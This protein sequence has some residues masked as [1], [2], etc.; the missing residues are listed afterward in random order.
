MEHDL[1]ELSKE[2]LVARLE[3][4]N[5]H[6]VT[7]LLSRSEELE[8]RLFDADTA[9]EADQLKIKKLESENKALLS[10][11]ME[12]EQQLGELQAAGAKGGASH[13]QTK[14]KLLDLEQKMHER[15][16]AEAATSKAID[17]L[18]QQ[19]AKV[20]AI[21]DTAE[22]EKTN[23][24]RNNDLRLSTEHAF[25]ELSRQYEELMAS[26]EAQRNNTERAQR[27]ASE[28]RDKLAAMEARALQA[29]AAAKSAVK[30]GDALRREAEQQRRQAEREVAARKAADE[31]AAKQRD[32][33]DS[34]R[35]QLEAASLRE[36][37]L[38]ADLE[39]LKVKSASW[40]KD[41]ER[42]HELEMQ[43]RSLQ[44][45]NDRQ[46]RE[47]EE[48]KEQAKE[49]RAMLRRMEEEER[50]RREEHVPAKQYQFLKQ[51]HAELTVK[52]AAHAEKERAWLK[53]RA[54]LLLRIKRLEL[55]LRGKNPTLMRMMEVEVQNQLLLG[56]LQGST[57]AAK[58]GATRRG[59]GGTVKGSR[60]V[61]RKLPPLLVDD[62]AHAP[63]RNPN[64]VR[65]SPRSVDGGP[66]PPAPKE[67][68]QSSLDGS[69][70]SGPA[71]EA[72]AAV[73]DE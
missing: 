32:E 52:L 65:E 66:L 21:A 22:E 56:M 38:K 20:K 12:A 40:K 3:A 44:S 61:P 51:Q 35:R 23:A 49:Y 63:P 69:L 4:L 70:H 6:N 34:L 71:D 41:A 15:V 55:E 10:R 26:L 11:T 45:L 53:E 57:T 9:K 27:E 28:L 36:E 68:V 43:V 5:G 48:L 7:D 24:A 42:A 46:A 33:I 25:E 47:S 17:E 16:E 73:S 30:D 18:Q 72:P 64:D 59:G 60:S 14:Q 1:R 62:G 2:E 39:A 54:E 19:L 67:H 50:K 13:E 58:P 37:R 31:L 29:E 8:R